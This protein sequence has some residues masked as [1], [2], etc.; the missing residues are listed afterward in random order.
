MCERVCCWACFS[1][2]RARTIVSYVALDLTNVFQLW[3]LSIR[4]FLKNG[5]SLSPKQIYCPA[6]MES[7][8]MTIYF[9]CDFQQLY[10]SCMWC[11]Q[12]PFFSFV[13]FSLLSFRH[14]NLAKK[15]RKN[16]NT[17]SFC[18]LECFQ[19]QIAVL[20]LSTK[21]AH[22][23]FTY[24]VIGEMILLKATQS[25]KECLSSGLGK[26]PGI[27]GKGTNLLAIHTSCLFLCE[28][29]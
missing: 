25:F 2:G 3:T 1:F 7:L 14:E 24:L 12:N 27:K 10:L 4:T 29:Y 18:D 17:Q 16:N 9:Y 15:Q 26:I 6:L 13:L 20:S 8:S 28:I 22:P 23:F 11:L 19:R 21:T 5:L